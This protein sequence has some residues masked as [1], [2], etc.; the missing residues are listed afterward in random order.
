MIRILVVD[1]HRAIREGLQAVLKMRAD[2]QVVGEAENGIQ[3]VEQ[4]GWT[5]PDVILM[6]VSMPGMDGIEA[7]RLITRLYPAIKV[8]V[9]SVT[10]SAD[11]AIHARQAGA[12]GCLD[13]N[14]SIDEIIM[15]IKAAAHGDYCVSAHVAE[16]LVTRHLMEQSR[17]DAA[18]PAAGSPG[19]VLA[20]LSRGEYVQELGRMLFRSPGDMAAVG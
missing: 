11:Q 12:T 3:A 20:F 10:D 7:T 17:R 4:A 2:F 16:L 19:A 9:L 13:K 8:L 5:R 6:D 14:C 15:G 18:N 1:D